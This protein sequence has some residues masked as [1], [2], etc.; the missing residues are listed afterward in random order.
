MKSTVLPNGLTI[1]SGAMAGRSSVCL[2]V[3][4]GV[5]SRNEPK[6]MNGASHFIEHMLF[7]GTLARSAKQISEAIEGIGGSINAF[8]EEE[9]TCFYSRGR[10]SHLPLMVEVLSDMVMR[11]T[12]DPEELKKERSVIREEI[13][14]YQDQPSSV[15]LDVL[16]ETMWPDQPLGRPILGTAKSLRS[17]KSLQLKEFLSLHYRSE[18]IVISATGNVDHQDLVSL[19]EKFWKQVPTGSAPIADPAD[20][21]VGK[22]PISHLTKPSEQ[23]YLALGVRTC[24]RHDIQRAELRLLN[25]LLAENMSSRLFQL[26][27]EDLGLAYHVDSSN[28]FFQDTG[29][30][31]ISAGVDDSKL[32]KASRLCVKELSGLTEK[33][34][35]Q[36][37]L[38]N[39]CDYL[40]GQ[41]ELHLESVENYMMWIGEQWLGYRQ[42]FREKDVY[43][44]LQKVTSSNL[45]RTAKRFFRPSN[46]HLTTVSS[47]KTS[48]ISTKIL[49]S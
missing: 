45:R 9:R 18:N 33:L 11:S 28:S 37:E 29:V 47:Q 43:E 48:S 13:I 21:M 4:V 2:G 6:K 36:K 26:L 24:S 27:R 16:N 39:A 7:K 30:L 17:L 42:L 34:V 14:Q 46:Y 44:R 1:V 38:G 22:T 8:T 19:V 32:A 31:T 25:V 15:V 12:F 49:N 40:I 41:S 23:A 10:A 20:D 35:S 5:G 3:W